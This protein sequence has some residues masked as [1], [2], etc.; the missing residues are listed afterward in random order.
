ML[1]VMA[2][3]TQVKKGKTVER[4]ATGQIVR[5]AMA[6]SAGVR[7]HVCRRH[8]VWLICFVRLSDP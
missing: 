3:K 5:Q 4:D 7:V 1:T 8:A 2:G 6:K